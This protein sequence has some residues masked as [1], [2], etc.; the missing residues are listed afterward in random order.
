MQKRPIKNRGR[1]VDRGFLGSVQ[2]F[3]VLLYSYVRN[4]R[5]VGGHVDPFF[6]SSIRQAE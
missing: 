5:W 1:R 3:L 2:I 6:I 4:E